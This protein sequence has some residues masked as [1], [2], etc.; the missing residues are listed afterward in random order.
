[1]DHKDYQKDVA[2]VKDDN[3]PRAAWKLG[4]TLGSIRGRDGRI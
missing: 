1:M 3:L 4:K 2:L